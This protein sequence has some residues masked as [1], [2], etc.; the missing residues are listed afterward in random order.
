MSR[1]T[2]RTCVKE[3]CLRVKQKYQGEYLR[4]AEPQDIQSI[5]RLHKDVHEVNGM[6]GSLDC[7]HVFWKN[8]P[9]AWQGQ[10]KGKEKKPT[11]VLEALCDHHMWLWHSSFGYA[12]T[13][14]DINILNL[15]PFLEAL[16]NGKFKAV[17]EA[18]KM[19]PYSINRG[20][21]FNQLFILTD[22]IYPPLSRFVK[23]ISM[24][25]L[26]GEKAFTA[27]QE[28]ARKDIERAFGVLQ[29]KFQVLA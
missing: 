21:K 22:G 28:S 12:G 2:A 16:K 20:D 14:N 1:T 8:C 24:P 9:V 7:M 29:G 15:S 23:G 3:F 6:Y 18:A 17:E 13:L 5:V 26:P 10:F 25:V 4:L 19:V 27:W 11:L